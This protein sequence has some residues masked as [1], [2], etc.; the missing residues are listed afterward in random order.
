VTVAEVPAPGVQPGHV[1]VRVAAS[2]VSAGTERASLEF[3]GKNLLQKASARP[4][5][6][7]DLLRK[8]RRDGLMSAVQLLEVDADA[9]LGAFPM[10]RPAE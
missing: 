6:V 9:F 10:H 4:D 3:A 8:V 1:L 2:L 5:L 7:S